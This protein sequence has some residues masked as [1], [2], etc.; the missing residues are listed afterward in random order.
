MARGKD[1]A[2]WIR[3]AVA[4]VNANANYKPRRALELLPEEYRREIEPPNEEGS[5]AE[6]MALLRGERDGGRKD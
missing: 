3:L 4:S 6:M 1:R 2:E 5:A